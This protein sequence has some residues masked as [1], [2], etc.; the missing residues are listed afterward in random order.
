M[1]NE[2]LLMSVKDIST[3]GSI[4]SLLLSREDLTSIYPGMCRYCISVFRDGVISALF[5]TNSYEYSPNCPL[6]AETVSGEKAVEWERDL[7]E[8]PEEFIFSHAEPSKI[9]PLMTSAEVV[10]LQGSPRGDGNC[11]TLAEWVAEAARELGK[12]TIIIFPN[13]MGINPCIG[14]YQ[15]YNTGS[16]TFTDE[17]EGV[18][19]AIEKAD[20]LVVCTPVYTNTVPG[21]LKIVIDRCL[22]YHAAHTL[23]PGRSDQKGILFA[24]AG[25]KGLS[26]FTC[27]KHVVRAFMEITGIRLSGELYIDEMDK[28]HDVRNIGGIESQVRAM[29]RECLQ[30]S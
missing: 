22:T 13:D 14:C 25:R 27:V 2:T 18:L 26:N 30:N 4:Y 3:G 17:M 20:F 24:V 8:N 28:R 7:R 5:R 15:C 23:V 12:T 10:V 19:F 11:S 29:V 9:Q 1:S 16:C 6:D 21:G